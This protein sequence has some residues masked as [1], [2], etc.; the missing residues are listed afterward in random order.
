MVELHLVAEIVDQLFKRLDAGGKL[1]IVIDERADRRGQNLCQSGLH[2]LQLVRR[3]LGEG[4]VLF[5]QL[6]R[7]LGN[8]QGVVGNTR[9]QRSYAGIWILLRSA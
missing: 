4:Q 3:R 2:D 8:I 7:S 9:N 6:L 5:V 1:Q